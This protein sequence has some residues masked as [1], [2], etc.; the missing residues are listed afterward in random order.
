M[1]IKIATLNEIDEIECL[2]QELFTEMSNLQPKYIKPAKQ[3]VT[4]VQNT[5]NNKDSDILIADI[6]NR[7]VGFLLIQET[8]TPPYSCIVEHQY[9]FIVDII[10]GSHYQNQ[11][12]GSTLL[13]EAKKWAKNRQLDYLELNV[14]TENI[15]PITLYEKQGFLD[16]NHTMRLELA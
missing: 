11:G 3:D 14:L 1:Q 6:D 16:M 12:I 7:T 4:F 13:S 8:T 10:V 15:G 9:A 5:I 2:Y